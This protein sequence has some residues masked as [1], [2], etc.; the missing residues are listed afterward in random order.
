ML[1][2]VEMVKRKWKNVRY[3]KMKLNTWI[4]ADKLIAT[5]DIYFIDIL[6]KEMH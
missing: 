2:Q 3:I 6:Q 4:N 5:F 1:L